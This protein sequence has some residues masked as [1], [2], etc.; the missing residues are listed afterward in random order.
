MKLMLGIGLEVNIEK[1]INHTHASIKK[2]AVT[3]YE[4]S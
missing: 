2:L 4:T 3:F 1:A